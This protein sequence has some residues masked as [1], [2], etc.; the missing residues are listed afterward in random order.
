MKKFSF[1]WWLVSACAV[2][3][4]LWVFVVFV[5][6]FIGRG[7][8]LIGNVCFSPFRKVD[9]PEW[10]KGWSYRLQEFYNDYL[11]L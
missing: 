8:L 3:M 11:E 4:S 6:L 10:V 5:F 9:P 7:L 1:K 2:A